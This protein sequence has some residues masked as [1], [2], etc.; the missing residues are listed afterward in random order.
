MYRDTLFGQ[1]YIGH[2]ARNNVN[3]EVQ[4]ANAREI[5]GHCVLVGL[6]PLAFKLF[7]LMFG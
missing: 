4:I 7:V 1:I 3:I 2:H 5:L 6:I